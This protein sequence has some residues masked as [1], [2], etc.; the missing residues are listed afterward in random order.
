MAEPVKV[1]KTRAGERVVVN[2]DQPAA[3]WIGA[4]AVLSLFCWLVLL[5]VRNRD[6]AGLDAQGRL[7]WSLTILTAVALIAHGI[8]LGRPVTAAHATAAMMVLFA[9]LGAG[10]A[11]PPFSQSQPR[12]G[13]SRRNSSGLNF[14][15][16]SF[17][18]S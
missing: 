13:Q 2:V 10:K 17:Q 16:M 6:R 1:A 14:T 15:E 4:L 8:F 18:R 11:G 7:A 3:R 12:R 5:L 9:G